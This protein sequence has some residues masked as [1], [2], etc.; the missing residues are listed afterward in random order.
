MSRF[1]AIYKRC[2]EMSKAHGNEPFVL[3]PLSDEAMEMWRA[4]AGNAKARRRWRR[5]DLHNTQRDA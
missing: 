5:R 1:L 4:A 2:E 3:F